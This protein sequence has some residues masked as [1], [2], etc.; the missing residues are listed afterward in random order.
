MSSTMDSRLRIV[1]VAL[2]V[3]SGL[4]VVMVA[5][6]LFAQPDGTEDCN[7]I[8]RASGGCDDDQPTFD[9]TD[10]R[11]VGEE[12]GRQ[13]VRRSTAIMDGGD[14]GDE[15]KAVR[16]FEQQLL[17]VQR[18]NQYLREQDIVDT[19]S[20]ETL[21][22]AAEGVLPPEFVSRIG[23]YLYDDGTRHSY[24]EWRQ[25]MLKVLQVVDEDDAAA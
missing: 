9:A 11:G 17:V 12:I 20:A 10:C 3:A 7:G 15:S 4:F 8:T 24:D 21:L 14:T 6:G 25:S 16:I 13:I 19:C 5:T 23:D 22:E 1:V 2:V 18:A